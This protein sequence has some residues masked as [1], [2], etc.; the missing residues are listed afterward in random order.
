MS[1]NKRLT[2]AEKRLARASAELDALERALDD[3]AAQL[4]AARAALGEDLKGVP[5]AE[6]PAAAGRQAKARADIAALET[7]AEELRRRIGAQQQAVR[8]ARAHWAAVAVETAQAELDN[9]SRAIL[10][11][12]EAV[13]ARLQAQRRREEEIY[14]EFN[15]WPRITFGPEIITRLAD[16]VAWERKELGA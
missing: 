3:T 4:D 5:L 15:T 1:E 10:A 16:K 8:T 2:E 13:L 12:L 9:E 11:D 14:Q 6:L 7:T